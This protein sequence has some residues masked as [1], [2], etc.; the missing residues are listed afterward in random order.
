MR[1]KPWKFAFDHIEALLATEDTLGYDGEVAAGIVDF[2]VFV[3][4]R[5]EFESWEVDVGLRHDEG[6]GEMERPS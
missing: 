2:A 3:F 4:G 5:I 6:V 1:V